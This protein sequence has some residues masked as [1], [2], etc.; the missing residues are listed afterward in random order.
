V[1]ITVEYESSTMY[2]LLGKGYTIKRILR[3]GKVEMVVDPGGDLC[4]G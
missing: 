3:S 2:L 4:L 1:M